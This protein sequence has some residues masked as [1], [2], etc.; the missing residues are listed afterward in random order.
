MVEAW[1]STFLAPLFPQSSSDTLKP[2]QYYLLSENNKE[3]EEFLKL[4]YDFCK[5]NYMIPVENKWVVMGHS[6]LEIEQAIKNVTNYSMRFSD[7]KYRTHIKEK[8]K[9]TNAN[10]DPKNVIS[11]EIPGYLPTK[12]KIDPDDYNNVITCIG[13]TYSSVMYK[14]NKERKHNLRDADMYLISGRWL[15]GNPHQLKSLDKYK[16]KLSFAFVKNE[17]LAKSIQYQINYISGG[18]E[19]NYIQD[20]I[21]ILQ[22]PD[23][24]ISAYEELYIFH[25]KGVNNVKKVINKYNDECADFKVNIE[26]EPSML[27]VYVTSSDKLNIKKFTRFYNKLN[28]E[29]KLY[30]NYKELQTTYQNIWVPQVKNGICIRIDQ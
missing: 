27:Y 22:K 25:K 18:F 26:V 11:V 20:L 6:I 16:V 30:K 1:L 21:K 12:E 7:G 5:K 28:L 23:N 13:N 15:C 19:Y 17:K 3:D 4:I 9:I 24:I 10:A 14:N 8:E 29:Y 2:S